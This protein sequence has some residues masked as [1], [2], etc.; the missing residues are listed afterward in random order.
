ML[1]MGCCK[2]GDTASD[3]LVPSRLWRLYWLERRAE[4]ARRGALGS[5]QGVPDSCCAQLH[6]SYI[7]CPPH[8]CLTKRRQTYAASSAPLALLVYLPMLT[9]IVSS[10]LLGYTVYLTMM[11]HDAPSA[12]LART[13]SLAV[14]TKLGAEKEGDRRKILSYG[15]LLGH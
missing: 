14:L 4:Q 11:A 2:D 9:E 10:T 3:A 6:L 12:L 13:V 8:P 1:T 5:T 15:R 7:D